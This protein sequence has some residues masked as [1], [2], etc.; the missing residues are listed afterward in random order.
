[1]EKDET[2][3]LAGATG[4][5]GDY[6]AQELNQRDIKTIILARNT[7]KAAHLAN[8]HTKIIKAEVTDSE[9]LH[10]YF[11]GVT[12]VI[13]TVGI[14]RQ[15]D[16]LTYMDVDYQANKNLL[17]EAKKAGVKKFVYVSVLNGK[18][19]RNL[20][21]IEAKELFVDE[22]IA[23]GLD[24]TIIRPNG[25]FSDMK[26]FLDMA[27]KGKVYLFGSGKKK[28]NPIHG[29]DL[30]IACVDSIKISN[31]EINIGGPE[32]LTHNEIAELALLACGKPIDII[33]LPHWIRT[34]ILKIVR[35]FTSSKNY[36]PIEFFLTL[37]AE[38]AVA[39]R[40]GS[41]RL[42]TFFQHEIDVL[43]P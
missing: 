8:S 22:L 12:T 33:H 39:P 31:Q 11:E 36:G 21:I 34:S 6:I 28:I 7:K 19:H 41:Q 10:G 25:F 32:I 40:Y 1:M 38:D 2:V 27:K 15:K 23:S 4:Y 5:L 30:A 16:G 13:S 17:Q 35:T 20:K 18:Q 26:D 43:K 14:T 9:T 37:M 29:K 24:Y 42:A 3:I